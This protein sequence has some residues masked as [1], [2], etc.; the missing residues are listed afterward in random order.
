MYSFKVKVGKYGRKS[1]LPLLSVLAAYAPFWG[2]S[3]LPAEVKVINN[4]NCKALE[5]EDLIDPC[6]ELGNPE[7][8]DES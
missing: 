3:L 7:T 5:H 1:P 2:K 4:H 8:R 6:S